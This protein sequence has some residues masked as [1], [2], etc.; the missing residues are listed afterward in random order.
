MAG[1]NKIEI[2]KAKN[3]EYFLTVKS[4]NNKKVMTS[5]ETYKSVQGVKKAVEAVKKIVKNAEVVDKT[6]KK[7]APKKK[8]T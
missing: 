2:N 3:D 8:A 6:A 7:A 5:G 4:A 1:K